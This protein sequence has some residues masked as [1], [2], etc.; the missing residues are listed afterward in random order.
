MPRSGA[1]VLWIMLLASHAKT[2]QNVDMST[3]DPG[4]AAVP[5]V[6]GLINGTS[7]LLY[8]RRRRAELGDAVRRRAPL[9]RGHP[10]LGWSILGYQLVLVAFMLAT[11]LMGGWTLQS[12]GL[13]IDMSGPAALVIGFLGYTALIT[14]FVYVL[15]R[16]GLYQQQLVS[17]VNAMAMLVPRDRRQ[18]KAAYAGIVLLNPVAEEFW[19]RGILVYQFALAT[20]WTG[21]AIALGAAISLLNHAYQGRFQVI[22]HLCFYVAATALLFSPLG[23]WGAIGFHIAGDLL[24]MHL[25]RRNLRE[26]RVLMR[27]G[28]QVGD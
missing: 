26:Y 19:F 9:R 12:V 10:R 22:F 20:Q 2:T 7:G 18:R 11:Y 21:A 6:W 28:H 27:R 1:V 13:E 25:L 8:R 24:P 5:I 16:T 14:I 15:R 17:V 4:L 3:I 23:L